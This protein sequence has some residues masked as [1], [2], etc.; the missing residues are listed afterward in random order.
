MSDRGDGHEV[1]PGDPWHPGWTDD[2]V[3][4]SATPPRNTRP[5]KP[6]RFGRRSRDHD[7]A[8]AE[9]EDDNAYSEQAVDRDARFRPAPPF[10]GSAPSESAPPAGD[11]AP[12]PGAP[13]SLE[14]PAWVGT[15]T[16]GAEVEEVGFSESTSPSDVRLGPTEPTEATTTEE[17][18][19]LSAPEASPEPSATPPQVGQAAFPEVSDDLPAEQVPPESAAVE[20]EAFDALRRLEA[21]ELTSDAADDP[22]DALRRLEDAKTDELAPI[23][24]DAGYGVAG[25]EAF[26]AL[27]DSDS[28]DLSDWEAFTG[29]ERAAGARSDPE[30]R[31]APAPVAEVAGGREP[32]DDVQEVTAAA[33]ERRGIWPFRRKHRAVSDEA[34]VATDRADDVSPVPGDWFADL[35]EG[36]AVV[37]GV[38]PAAATDGPV[39]VGAAPAATTSASPA[40]EMVGYPAAVEES[41][42][43]AAIPD[44]PLR[45]EDAATTAAPGY[46]E[47][48]SEDLRSG[49]PWRL[50]FDDGTS[51]ESFDPSYDPAPAAAVRGDRDEWAPDPNWDPEATVEMTDPGL[52][53]SD[54]VYG[55]AGTMEHRGL[56]EEIHRLGDE[57]TE[58]QAMSAAMPG[59]ETGVVGFEDV[60]DLKTGDQYEE[61]PRS[62]LG[63]RVGTGLLLLVFLLG[64]MFVGGAAMAVFVG[65]MA[66]LGIWEF[67]GTLRRLEFQPLALIG[68]VGAVGVLAAAWFHGPIAVPVGLA[69]L[70][71]L[72][73]FVYAFSPLRQDALANGG[74]TVLAVAWVAGTAAFATPILRQQDFRVLVMALVA[75]TI[76]MDV[77][78]FVFGRTWGSRALAP[79]VSPHKSVEG[80]LGGVLLTMGIGVAFGMLVEPFDTASGIALGAVVSVMAPLGDLGESMVKRSLG[81]KDMG[82]VLP[83]HGGV[84]DRI[85]GF[86]FVLPA[87]WVLYRIVGLLG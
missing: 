33:S 55:S 43:R 27:S 53:H 8:P 5:K 82:T 47:D 77:G 20:R 28:E 16:A 34:V 44:S 76:A 32:V 59:I 41:D 39:E 87:A 9:A 21:G 74:L 4:Q 69:L 37:P 78:A 73:F 1:H 66:L 57:D 79:M 46:E 36:G 51:E 68:Y 30:P 63:A 26:A 65:A 18:E 40:G 23:A 6:R 24:G 81:V 61:G 71:V 38:D 62:D 60:A 80:L 85:D 17:I 29:P 7:Q 75:A 86:L 19:V 31:G 12:Q 84:L 52:R 49:G 45:S 83:G 54:E 11:L 50:S 22:F 48:D 72:V 3:E 42:P 14:I 64:T 10:V 25:K 56:A 15:A 35:A 67:Y 13:A 58:W 2:A 70:V